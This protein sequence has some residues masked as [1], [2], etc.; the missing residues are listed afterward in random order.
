VGKCANAR[1]DR[2]GCFVY[3]RL[4]GFKKLIRDK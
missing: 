4:I 1:F 3:K 2:H